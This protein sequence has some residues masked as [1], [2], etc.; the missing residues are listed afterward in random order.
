METG[1]RRFDGEVREFVK[2]RDQ[3]SRCIACLGK[4][5]DMEH[6]QDYA[7]DC[8]TTAGNGAGLCERCHHLEDHEGM[9][10]EAVGCSEPLAP[11]PNS[12]PGHDVERF[13]ARDHARPVLLRWYT[14]INRAFITQAPSAMGPGTSTLEQLKARQERV[15]AA[16]HAASRHHPATPPSGRWCGSLVGARQPGRAARAVSRVSPDSHIVSKAS[17]R[18]AASMGWCTTSVVIRS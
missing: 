14:P 5:R 9:S 4:I 12:P 1:R 7:L 11:D 17:L 18:V 10:C 15:R 2:R 6:I 16:R 13:K 3:R 8:P